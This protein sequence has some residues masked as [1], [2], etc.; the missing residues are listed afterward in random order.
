MRTAIRR[1]FAAVAA[2]GLTFSAAAPASAN[3]Q[4]AMFCQIESGSRTPGKCSYQ[5][6]SQFGY[7]VTFDLDWPIAG[8]RYRWTYGGGTLLYACSNVEPACVLT[9]APRPGAAQATA[10]V[11][12]TYPDG[13]TRFFR[14]DACMA[15][16]AGYCQ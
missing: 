3:P 14:G 16:G 12:A 7:H 8:A 15:A 13:T 6:Q 9:V 11:T 10:S 2:T 1:A 4:Q 5:G